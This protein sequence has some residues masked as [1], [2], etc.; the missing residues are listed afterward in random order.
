MESRLYGSL[1]PSLDSAGL[2]S[3]WGNIWMGQKT[4]NNKQATSNNQ[5]P[6][7]TTTTTTAKTKKKRNTAPYNGFP[8]TQASR[9][10]VPGV[11]P[12]T[13]S[14]ESWGNNRLSS[15]KPTFSLPVFPPSQTQELPTHD[16]E[17]PKPVGI[18]DGVRPPPSDSLGN[19]LYPESL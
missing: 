15:P 12:K 3:L 6:T 13:S 1:A 16:S 10:G 18:L 19:G 17:R 14:P 8:N 11:P 4:T 9:K 7:T 5:Q 2:T